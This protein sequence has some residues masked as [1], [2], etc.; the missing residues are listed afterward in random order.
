MCSLKQRWCD[1]C[2]RKVQKAEN[3]AKKAGETDFFNELR[4]GPIIQ[5]RKFMFGF[6]QTMGDV[7]GRGNRGDGQF[8]WCRHLLFRNEWAYSLRPQCHT[9]PTMPY[10]HYLLVV[11]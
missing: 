3:N 6:V 4:K 8:D 2:K 11:I 9:T 1:K 5:F 10:R 7:V